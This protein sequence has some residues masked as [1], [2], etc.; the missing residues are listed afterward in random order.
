MSRAKSCARTLTG[1]VGNQPLPCILSMRSSSLLCVLGV[2]GLLSLVGCG[3]SVEW[4]CGSDAS[5]YQGSTSFECEPT[6]DAAEAA[7]YSKC[8]DSEMGFEASCE[9]VECTKTG[10]GECSSS[11]E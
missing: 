3:P 6:K 8:D 7:A 2:M 10:S 9:L 5:E 11:E 4:E 1:G